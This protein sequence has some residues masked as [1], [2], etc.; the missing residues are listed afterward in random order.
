MS[1]EG[2]GKMTE[3]EMV[4]ARINGLLQARKMLR[5]CYKVGM[6]KDTDYLTT[7]ERL[8]S[9]IENICKEFLTHGEWIY[10]L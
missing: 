1:Q 5:E 6:I 8:F 2:V 9:Q 7:D 4:Y 10:S 3:K